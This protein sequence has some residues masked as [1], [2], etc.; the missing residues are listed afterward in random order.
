MTYSRCLSYLICSMALILPVNAQ[1]LVVGEPSCLDLVRALRLPEQIGDEPDLS[2]GAEW[3]EVDR[4]LA[5]IKS[6]L[7][8]RQCR[9]KFRQVF[10]KETFDLFPLTSRIL[11]EVPEG[12]LT[13]I[14]LFSPGGEK[15][16]TLDGR[17]TVEEETDPDERIYTFYFARYRDASGGL[18]SLQNHLLQGELMVRWDDVR[19]RIAINTLSAGA[20]SAVITQD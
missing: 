13:G 3:I 7:Q 1:D 8:G 19:E 18:V 11:A 6:G 10:N 5:A 15:L 14:E 4:T 17:A 2:P 12:V 9:L 20:T 16:G